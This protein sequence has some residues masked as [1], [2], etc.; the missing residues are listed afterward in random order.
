M[1]LNYREKIFLLVFSVIVL[2]IIACAWPIR[3]LRKKIEAN[4]NERK[5][6]LQEF[7]DKEQKIAQIKPLEN[8]IETLYNESSEYSKIFI[9]SKSNDEIDKYIADVLNDAQEYVCK[10]LTS[11]AVEILGNHVISDAKNV[12]LDF[13]YLEPEIVTY[14]IMQ[15]ADINGNLMETEN[16]DFYDKVMN[17][18]KIQSLDPQEVESHNQTISV[19]ATKAGLFK[20][21]DQIAK[22]DSGIKI[23]D[24]NIADPEYA[25]RKDTNP[26]EVPK[27]FSRVDI[28]ISYYTMQ[29]IARPAF[30]DDKTK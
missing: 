25:F 19:L 14:P 20:F 27:G 3:S 8:Q 28:T 22:I 2:V 15:A 26:E 4:E 6:V 18:A 24:I 29:K 21:I 11:N 17:A 10:D 13:S 16:K 5:I 23:T 1:K 7:K 9:D 12:K 30:L